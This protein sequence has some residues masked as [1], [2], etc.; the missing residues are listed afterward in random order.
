MVLADVLTD[1]G[2]V[3]TALAPYVTIAVSLGLGFRLAGWVK[4]AVGK[5]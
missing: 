3:F 4:R 1:M 2:A 5:R